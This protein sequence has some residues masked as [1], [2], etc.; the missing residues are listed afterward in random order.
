MK[1]LTSIRQSLK[2]SVVLTCVI[3]VLLTVSTVWLAVSIERNQW[4]GEQI[5]EYKQ[6][7][8][9]QIGNEFSDLTRASR[10]LAENPDL[11]IATNE[12]NQQ[13]IKVLVEKSLLQSNGVDICI[14]QDLSGRIIY[15]E[16]HSE[17]RYLGDL[18][19]LHEP[20]DQKAFPLIE[21]TGID[22]VDG[23]IF[24]FSSVVIGANENRPI[25]L[26]TL[27][28]EVDTPI[29]SRISKQL[30]KEFN[31]HYTSAGMR[32]TQISYNQDYNVDLYRVTDKNNGYEAEYQVTMADGRVQPANFLIRFYDSKYTW[33]DPY[34]LALSAAFLIV[35]ISAV[36]WVRFGVRVV[37]PVKA[38][39]ELM[40]NDK[41][42][43]T[44]KI[45]DAHFPQELE[46]IYSKFQKV[47]L[48][49]SQ[50]N[51][52]SQVLV[53]AIGDIIITVNLDGVIC[54]ANPAARQWFGVCETLLIGQP[55]ELF[56]SNILSDTPD[57]ATWLYRSNVTKERVSTNC[58]LVSL[59]C[60]QY[61]YPAD[62]IVQPIEVM[63]SNRDISS[64]VVVIR[65]KGRIPISEH[66]SLG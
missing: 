48:N 47:Y 18:R 7:A 22:F 2:T 23:R 58:H 46:Q 66:E 57:V 19:K 61:I 14:T 49:M 29:L 64:S 12:N 27:F 20:F 37:K 51:Q 36:I 43:A 62:V 50:Q 65:I 39:T 44:Q 35:L 38:L 42:H 28:R 8:V 16:S 40:T 5:E 10:N 31:F 32:L 26:L 15:S 30:G 6:L 9:I 13:K 59:I 54:Y 41:T 4:R 55:L 3:S 1:P 17:Q 24:M 11:Y 53:D 52:F 60:K 56:T 33:F 21:R 45:D 63:K 25:G 34:R